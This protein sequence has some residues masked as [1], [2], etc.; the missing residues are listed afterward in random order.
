MDTPLMEFERHSD[1]IVGYKYIN[2]KKKFQLTCTTYT[3]TLNSI[4]QL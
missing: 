2:N 4:E 3:L 1:I